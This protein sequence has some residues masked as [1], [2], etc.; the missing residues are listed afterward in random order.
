MK[1]TI[2][3]NNNFEEKEFYKK[4]LITNLLEIEGEKQWKKKE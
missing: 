3:K 4:S 2:I 1:L